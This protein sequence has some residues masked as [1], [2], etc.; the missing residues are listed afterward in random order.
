MHKGKDAMMCLSALLVLMEP[1]MEYYSVGKTDE[2]SEKSRHKERCCVLCGAVGA[3][4]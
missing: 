2:A 1:T 3:P 4:G